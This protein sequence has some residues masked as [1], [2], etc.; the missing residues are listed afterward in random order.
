MIG[1]LVV[2]YLCHVLNS[3]ASTTTLPDKPGFSLINQ[4]MGRKTKPT[5]YPW[6][7]LGNLSG[8]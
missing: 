4:C 2:T 5:I 6:F 1:K 7:G 3:F 8:K